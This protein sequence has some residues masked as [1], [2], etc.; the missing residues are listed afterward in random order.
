MDVCTV[1]SADAVL[2]PGYN[3]D[4]GATADWAVTRDTRGNSSYACSV[5]QLS[6]RVGLFA[7]AKWDSPVAVLGSL[8]PSRSGV[9]R[10][11]AG[12]PWVG[13][14]PSNR[15]AGRSD[16]N[17]GGKHVPWSVQARTVVTI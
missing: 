17:A 10:K 2:E 5:S 13:W 9:T 6:C 14:K 1:G 8:G 3:E 16:N 12:V 11:Y 15:L 7:D 4:D